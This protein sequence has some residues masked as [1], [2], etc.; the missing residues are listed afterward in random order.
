M[1]LLWQWKQQKR[2]SEIHGDTDPGLKDRVGCRRS[3][4]KKSYWLPRKASWLVFSSHLGLK[5]WYNSP[6]SFSSPSQA[7]TYPLSTQDPLGYSLY[8]PALCSTSQR[9]SVCLVEWLFVN[10]WISSIQRVGKLWPMGK[11]R[12]ATYFCRTWKL[13]LWLKLKLKKLLK[14]IKTRMILCDTW[15]YMK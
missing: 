2:E 3:T 4:A 10:I 12:P 14:I 7:F 6:L 9:A 1:L 5:R 11:V 8:R 15:N 13:R